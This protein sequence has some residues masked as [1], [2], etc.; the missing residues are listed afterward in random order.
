MVQYPAFPPTVLLSSVFADGSTWDC[1]SVRYADREDLYGHT[2]KQFEAISAIY[3]E[4][5][6]K[7]KHINIVDLLIQIHNIINEHIEVE[8]LSGVVRD[9]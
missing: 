9:A 5:Q 2:R 3:G 7:R 6:K 4:L 1:R 8:E